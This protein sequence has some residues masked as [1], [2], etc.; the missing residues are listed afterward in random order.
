MPKVKTAFICQAC[1]F[2]TPKWQGQCPSCGEWNSLVETLVSTKS[3]IKNQKSNIVGKVLKLS[4]VDESSSLSRRMEVG[5]SEFSQVLGGGLVPGSVTL[6]AGEPGIGKSTL[7][8]QLTLYFASRHGKVLYV[9]GEESPEQV[10]LRLDRLSEHKKTKKAAKDN[11][12]L[13]SEIDTDRVVVT[14]EAER[15]ML[16]IV[17]S[18]QSLVVGDLSGMAGSV[19]Q[20]RESGNRLL[21]LAK[22]SGLST[23]LVGHV[24]KAGAVAGPKVLE[25]MVDSVLQL[26]G[27]RSGNLRI[28]RAAKNRFGPV[29][30]VAVYQMGD[31]GLVEVT[32]PSEAFLSETQTGVA[33]SCVT[34]V[35]EGTRAL[36]T[37]VQALVVD[38]SLPTPRRVAEG[39]KTSRLNVLCAVLQKR[40]GIALY[41][42]DVFVNV[43]G[44]L[45]L[46]E[47]ASDLGFCLAIAS[48]YLD[49]PLPSKMAAFGEVGL[50]GEVRRVGF[51]DRRVREAKKLGYTTVVDGAQM[52]QIGKIV[53][54]Y[55]KEK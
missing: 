16:T 42:K 1:E 9:C 51:A 32:N 50:L 5:S 23:F 34:V 10:K 47:P 37:E 28:L 35:M 31:A 13:L 54:K 20:V 4:E 46:S 25:H 14:M 21:N 18:I 39:I 26:T 22:S 38:S 24:T 36:L 43:A 33:G 55:L 44:G 2:E 41:D 19:G 27:E 7:L 17:D 45:R 3:N 40:A 11:I 30:E 29:D 53:R 49:R 8:S 15:P 48:S 12:L 52:G 6:L